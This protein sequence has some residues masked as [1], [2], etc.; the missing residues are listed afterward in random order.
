MPDH[1]LTGCRPVPLA[2]YLKALAVLR[3]VGEQADR[4]AR[5]FW[6]GDTFVLRTELDEEA[7]IRFFLHEYEPTPI[8]APWNGGSGFYAK[9]NKDAI[10]RI[11]GSGTR[12][13]ATYRSVIGGAFEI[14]RG[15]GIEEKVTAEAKAT[16]LEDCRARL[17]DAALAWLD[18]AYL[19][20][21][22]GAKY[23]P[24]L[25]TGGNDGRLDFTNNFMQ[26][27]LDVVDAQSGGP[28]RNSL[29]LVRA[30]F[31]D[32]ASDEMAGG[33]IGQFSPSAAGGANA[34][35]GFDGSALINPWD[36][37][38]MLEGA[39]AFAVAAV[40]RLEHETRG[41]L[42]YPF[43]VRPAGVGYASASS[44]DE[45]ASR[46]EMWLPMWERPA[47]W[48]EILT[49]LGEGR[50]RVSGR[51]ARNGVDFAR[52]VATLGVDRG[53]ARFQR[54]G[55]Q[56]RNGLAYLAT[57]LERFRVREQPT[58][59]LLDELDAWL[60]GFRRRATADHAPASARRALGV[61]EDATVDLCRRG[62]PDR[63][64]AVLGALGGCERAMARSIRWASD[65]KTN[66]SP[67]P[68]LSPKWL[69][70]ADDGSVEL[71]LATALASVVA[72]HRE[73]YVPVRA[74]LEPVRMR[75]HQGRLRVEWSPTADRD[76]VFSDGDLTASLN[77][78]VARR[79]I[80]C[81]RWGVDGYPD[82]SAQPARL[83]D[84]GA[85]IEGRTDDARIVALLWG[86]ILIDWARYGQAGF[87]PLV[88]GPAPPALY[89]LLKLCF[90][91]SPAPG[92]RIP[93]VPRIHRLA[94]SGDGSEASR[95]AARRLRASGYEPAVDL[96]HQ[97]GEPARR[98]AAA[99]LFPLDSG[100]L[101]S[102]RRTVL[103]PTP[104]Q[105]V[106]SP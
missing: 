60:D 94:A 97:A 102:L 79:L 7:L 10:E 5:G 84:V 28:T 26:R 65:P 104:Q 4:S 40:R 59:R 33:A 95:A 88:Q 77:A 34:G 39:A 56:V 38:L 82:R 1:R 83:A 55:L 73:H 70:E 105:G 81:E 9:D 57:P 3:L 90:A 53:I 18:A 13:L 64:Q 42:S 67:V 51:T 43:T 98:A 96:V 99:V 62:G 71:R 74:H 78:I 41:A 12:R 46:G 32:E 72:S 30:A 50:A 100:A 93:V 45:G 8:I 52:A 75:V 61:L 29:S 27:L 25:G 91:G 101:A 92:D 17:P 36:F 48:V 19:I 11:V 89:G 15:R 37:V 14:L 23:P 31:F 20:T 24:L 85:F 58:V 87:P 21:A 49:L 6:D 86:A 68:S 2:S 66:L 47:T 69:T 22:D 103:R 106:N 35:A 63:V 16:L 54:Y 44:A 76:V 80:L